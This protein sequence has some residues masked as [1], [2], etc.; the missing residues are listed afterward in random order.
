MFYI[1][2]TS[3]DDK[4]NDTIYE[5]IYECIGGAAVFSSTLTWS[6]LVTKSYQYPNFM[7]HTFKQLVPGSKY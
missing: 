5:D 6:A 4:E 7:G 3:D 1:I 2:Y